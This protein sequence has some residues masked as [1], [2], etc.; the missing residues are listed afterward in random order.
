MYR[1][2]RNV[3]IDG[4]GFV[5]G[6]IPTPAGGGS[7]YARTDVGGAYVWEQALSR[8]RPIT[9]SM[10]GSRQVE[11]LAADP[12]QPRL[13]YIAAG[14]AVWRSTNDGM[15][16]RRHP[17]PVRME[18]NGDGRS[19]GERLA[20][21]P[22]DRSVL[23]FGSRHDGLFRSSDAGS[24][25]TNVAGF[26]DFRPGIG[27]TF[28]LFDA[29]QSTPGSPTRTLYAGVD[30]S[31][32]SVYRSTD[33]GV[34]WAA[35]LNQPTNG[36]FPNHAVL[37][38]NGLLF[39]TY[40]N[41]GGPNGMT[42]GAVWRLDTESGAWTDLS[43]VTPGKS[44]GD[45]F[46]Y[47]GVAVDP[48][49]A[50]SLLVTSMD[51]WNYGDAMWHSTNAGAAQPE[52]QPL[53]SRKVQPRWISN[54]PYKGRDTHWMSDVEFHPG[55]RGQVF[56]GF[57]LGVHRTDNVQA[58]TNAIWR[59]SA[60]GIEE[61]VVLALTSPTSGPRLLSGLG[62]IGGFAHP[63]LRES[64]PV[65]HSHGNGVS[66]DFAARAPL[67]LARSGS[68]P[69][70]YS[71]NGGVTWDTFR[72][73]PPGKQ[74]RIAV[75]ADGGAFLW[76][77]DGRAHVTP[78]RG[79]TW[80]PVST[81]PDGSLIVSDRVNPR[82]FL[83][84]H[85]RTGRMFHSDDS[86]ET[87]VE[88]ATQLPGTHGYLSAQLVAVP[89]RAGEAYATTQNWRQ[90]SMLHRTVDGGRTWKVVSGTDHNDR[91]VTT[92]TAVRS[93]GSIGLGLAMPGRRNPS[94]YL[95]GTLDLPRRGAT[96]GIFRSD[97]AG[98]TWV[99]IDD[100][101]QRFGVRCLTGDGRVPGRLYVGTDGRGI[102]YA[103]P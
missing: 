48:H 44:S 36:C 92:N 38:S 62:D 50:D 9:D 53:F 6:L 17:L 78:D 67:V 88:S 87:F 10:E 71:T 102:I 29:R 82:R 95:A 2:W 47:G 32:A 33:A 1:S 72:S 73:V 19:A 79:V 94:L 86:G 42:N 74:G 100:P 24:T 25:W 34:T 46:G 59:F 3:R 41:T 43:P 40:A 4:G 93:I 84:F 39:L 75:S 28:V 63:S 35:V 101:T 13:L 31:N 22:N 56:F 96:R 14:G 58:G 81:L 11:S 26:T 76:T 66:V 91:P 69:P 83:A 52:W 97:D 98:A 21:D 45:F 61:T 68:G 18:G 23:F 30:G 49:Q 80:R 103:D 65:Q 12:V 8:W 27:I 57:G 54:T 60:E 64:P 15:A 85:T 90:L 16:W 77:P 20:I 99:R 5:T 55:Q 37:S 51:R 7:M 70:K 89:G